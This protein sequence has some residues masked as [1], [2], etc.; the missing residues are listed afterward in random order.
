MLNGTTQTGLARNVGDKIEQGDFTIKSVATNAD[1]SVASTVIS[2]TEGHEQAALEV[3]DIIEVAK[4]SVQPADANTTTAADADVV[5][6][7]GS[8]K[9]EGS[10]V[11]R[12][13]D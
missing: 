12:P 3:A 13:R 4:S 11:Q 6:T 9:I 2:Y 1:Q 8:D 10:S 7:V 5:V